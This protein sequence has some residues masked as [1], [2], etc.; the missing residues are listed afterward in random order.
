[1]HQLFAS[2]G[3][4]DKNCPAS[5]SID[6][7]LKTDFSVGLGGSIYFGVGATANVSFDLKYFYDQMN[8]LI[9]NS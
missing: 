5:N 2:Y 1:M 4:W 3:L 7:K 9:F 8:D 6:T